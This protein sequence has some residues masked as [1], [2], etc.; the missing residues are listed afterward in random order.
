[1]SNY[2]F[3]LARQIKGLSGTAHEDL[4]TWPTVYEP[5]LAER[6]SQYLNR[7]QAIIDYLCG[8]T[9]NSLKARYGLGL[10]DVYRLVVKRCLKV[11]RDGQIYGWR[12]LVRYQ[13]LEPYTRIKPIVVNG[14][15][16]G[17]AGAMKTLFAL[18]PELC[19]K[20]NKRILT[21]PSDD[22]LEEKRNRKAHWRWLLGELRKKGYE[23]RHE[24]PFNTVNM[25]YTSVCRY[26]NAVLA[27]N[28]TKGAM[29]EGGKDARRKMKSGDGVD[30]PVERLFQRVEMDAHKLD[31]RFCVLFP[32]GDGSY[33]PNI[34]HRLWVIVLLEVVSRAVLGYFLSVRYEISKDD[35]LRAIK[36]ALTQWR[37]RSI[38]FGDVAYREGAALPSGH[39]ER[40]VGVCW[41]ETSVDGALAETSKHVRQ[42]LDDLVGS[43]L[44]DPDTCF[45]AR[46]SKD[47]RPFIETFFRHLGKEG[48]QR[49]TNTTGGNPKG[50]Q[51]RDP[52]KIAV[53][54]SFQIEYAEDL[55]DALIAN[56]NATEHSNLGGRSPLEYLDFISSRPG[57]PALRYADADEIQ[58]FLSYRKLCTVCGNLATGR[59]PHVNFSNAPHHGDAL[60]QRF[61]LIGKK[62]WVENHIEYD[63]RIALAYTPEGEPLGVLRA[64]PPWHK[65]PHSLVVRAGIAAFFRRKRISLDS[66]GD[67]IQAFHRFCEEHQGE[68]PVHPI[69]LESLRILAQ[70]AEIDVGDSVL[71]A[72]LVNAGDGSALHPD[73]SANPTRAPGGQYCNVS[74]RPPGL[75]ARRRAVTK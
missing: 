54:S 56:Y 27:A 3:P 23:I 34:I 58:R 14:A 18:E 7:K 44:L 51:G 31:G 45:S 62:I 70:Y 16:R 61:D 17:A 10:K 5:A 68:L 12:A 29:V 49:L 4:S 65:T 24:W 71:E 48:F 26:V 69:Y 36:K 41:D 15:G 53:N 55:L 30:R 74:D 39:D 21:P 73:D 57:E 25:G 8:A 11:H 46:R 72:A 1:M 47:D 64:A 42:I 59:K 28:P 20:F 75:P 38:A 40:Y 66:I 43:R 22:K 33:A 67:A 35:V 50:K 52:E 13:H 32:R 2:P 37:R 9:D 19:E 63:A 6:L 60:D